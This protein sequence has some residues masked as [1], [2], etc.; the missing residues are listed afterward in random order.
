MRGRE[1]PDDGGGH[2][3]ESGEEEEKKTLALQREVV[4]TWMMWKLC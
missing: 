4:D 1:S 2:W 3:K